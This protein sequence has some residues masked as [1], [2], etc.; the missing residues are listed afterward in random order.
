MPKYP[1]QDLLDKIAKTGAVST[2]SFTGPQELEAHLRQIYHAVL[3]VDLDAYEL[4]DLK[5]L[6]PLIMQQLFAVR[7]ALRD[8]I[9]TWVEK[10][11]VTRR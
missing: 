3:G 5:R 7:M 10:G 1:A 11:W 6:A 2:K 9:A 8:E 4:E